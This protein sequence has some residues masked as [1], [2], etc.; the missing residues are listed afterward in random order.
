MLSVNWPSLC[1]V[2]L[3][4]KIKIFLFNSQVVL[5][6]WLLV[7]WFFNIVA[8]KPSAFLWDH[9]VFW[10]LSYS[11]V[12]TFQVTG[13]SALDGLRGLLESLPDNAFQ[14]ARLGE[15]FDL[16][17]R[18]WA[19]VVGGLKL[20]GVGFVSSIGTLSVSNGIWAIRK[21]LKP[22]IYQKPTNKRSPVIKTALVY[23]SFLG[24]SANLRYQVRLMDS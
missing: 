19:V 10:V 1:L 8:L 9:I 18:L 5:S 15:N 3:L 17:T 7:K 4:H 11:I 13:S 6:D 21:V 24:L 12:F 14:R 23:G 16:S 22:E 2:S 20:F